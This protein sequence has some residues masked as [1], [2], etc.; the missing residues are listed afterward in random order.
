MKR[1]PRTEYRFSI[2]Y[3]AHVNGP[4][5]KTVHNITAPTGKAAALL[6]RETVEQLDG[7][8]PGSFQA[9]RIKATGVHVY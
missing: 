5:H 8:N 6:V 3:T 7:Y 9:W 1:Q 4:I 2:T